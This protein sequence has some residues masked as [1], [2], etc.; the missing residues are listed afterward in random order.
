MN[1]RIL[2]TFDLTEATAQ[3]YENLY[4]E[5]SALGLITDTSSISG[6]GKQLPESTVV[7]EL[8]SSLTLASARENIVNQL[9]E[10]FNSIGVE[11]RYLVSVSEEPSSTWALR[12]K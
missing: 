7:G 11:Y 6:K 9:D 12:A 3:D 5:L 2:C 4:T 8:E 1:Y 10:A